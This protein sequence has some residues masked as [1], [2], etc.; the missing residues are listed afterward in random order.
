MPGASRTVRATARLPN[1]IDHDHVRVSVSGWHVA[2]AS[3][4]VSLC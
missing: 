2:P 1:G 3:I 4:D